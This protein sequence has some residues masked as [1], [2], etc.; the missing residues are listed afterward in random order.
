MW[1]AGV[2]Y[3]AKSVAFL[4]H[5]NRKIHYLLNTKK[6]KIINKTKESAF[7]VAIIGKY[8]GKFKVKYATKNPDEKGHIYQ[9]YWQQFVSFWRKK[10]FEVTR[11]SEL[12]TALGKVWGYE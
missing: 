1:K 6:N 4:I 3:S 2:K 10:D 7:V 11:N 12:S 8:A 5:L 9:F